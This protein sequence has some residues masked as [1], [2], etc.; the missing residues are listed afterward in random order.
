MGDGE[1]T[2]ARGSDAGAAVTAAPGARARSETTTLVFAVAVA[3]ALGCG[4][5]IWINSLM[6]SAAS[7]GRVARLQPPPDAPPPAEEAATLQAPAE[8]AD[9]PEAVKEHAEAAAEAPALEPAPA[10]AARRESRQAEEEARPAAAPRAEKSPA[11]EREVRRATPCALYAGASSLTMRTGGAAFLVVGGPGEG[12]P[13]SVSTPSWADIVV[14]Q[15]GPA[16]GRNGWTRY[17]VK[18]V[19]KRPGLYTVRFATRCGSQ[20]IPVTVK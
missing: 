15:E 14:F 2:S 9:T 4:C 3:V 10:P 19:S 11:P 5:G 18:S 8:T 6:S 17:T 1:R 12:G 13:V 16:P 7:G 20:T